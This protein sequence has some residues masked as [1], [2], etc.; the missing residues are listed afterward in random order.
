MDNPALHEIDD[1]RMAGER[2]TW[3]PAEITCA[4]RSG[5]FQ[6]LH[7]NQIAFAQVVMCRESHAISKSTPNQCFFES[8]D[9]LVTAG[10]VVGV[11]ANGSAG[12]IARRAVL[13]DAGERRLRSSVNNARNFTAEGVQGE[14]DGIE[15]RGAHEFLTFMSSPR[16]AARFTS[17]KAR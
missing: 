11:T 9:A 2:R 1:R 4:E 8:C 10:W 14:F 13:V 15:S 16:S 7:R 6:H 12:F 17:C 5:G 3:E